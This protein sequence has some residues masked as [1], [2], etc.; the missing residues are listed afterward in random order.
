MNVAPPYGAACGAT[1]ADCFRAVPSK[2]EMV[3][4]AISVLDRLAGKGGGWILLVEQSQIDKLAHP[5]EYE[6]VIYETLELDEALGAVQQRLARRDDALVVVAA[7]HAQP[8][9]II[10]V[11]MPGAIHPGGCFSGSAYP[12]TLGSAG[13]PERPCALQD[14]I[15]TFNDGT[16]PTYASAR[17]DGYPDDPD[18]AVKLVLEDGGRPTYSTNYLTNFQ[19][20]EPQGRNAALPNP[21]RAADGLLMTGNMP[22]RNVAGGANKTGKSVNI[23]PHS[24]D[25]VPWSASGRGAA[26]FA[27]AYEN[28]DVHV[29]IAAA[30]QGASSR[31]DLRRG[32]AFPA[33]PAVAPPGARLQGL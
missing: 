33:V 10:G 13:D 7:D 2:K 4:K 21:Q 25:D 14:A 23:A 15:G 28:T 27:G 26:L 1:I 22:T 17:N 31:K 24:G 3:D 16:A 19:P 18:P 6:R 29:M 8:E 20:L 12:L 5:L 30:L 32:S 9:T 11:V